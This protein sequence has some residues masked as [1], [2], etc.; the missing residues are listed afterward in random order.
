M[1]ESKIIIHYIGM[2]ITATILGGIGLAAVSRPVPAYSE[3]VLDIGIGAL[4]GIATGGGLAYAALKPRR[5]EDPTP[6]EK[7]SEE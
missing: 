4:A 2:A 3:R 7:E 1:N 6:R 5:P